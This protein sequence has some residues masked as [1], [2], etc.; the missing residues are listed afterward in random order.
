MKMQWLNLI[1][2][3]YQH[4][5]TNSVHWL[6]LKLH[7]WRW[8]WQETRSI[9][10]SNFYEH[11]RITRINIIRNSLMFRQL[12]DARL[13]WYGRVKQS[14]GLKVLKSLQRKES[15]VGQT[16]DTWRHWEK[17]RGYSPC[18]HCEAAEALMGMLAWMY[19]WLHTYLG[20]TPLF[21]LL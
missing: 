2:R 19:I 8:Q 10:N 7:V 18:V 6:T 14:A 11:L 21:V 12:I 20:P 5:N 15:K 4:Y 9:Q 17:T 13:H 1:A 16:D 3:Y